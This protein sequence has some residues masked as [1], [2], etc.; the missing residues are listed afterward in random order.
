MWN[1]K[2]QALTFLFFITGV[3]SNLSGQYSNT[4]YFMPDIIQSRYLNPA[5][6]QQCKFTLGV[7]A[8]SSFYFNYANNAASYNDVLGRGVPHV[9]DPQETVN[10]LHKKNY[11]ETSIQPTLFS[12][13]YRHKD[14]T[15]SFDIIEKINLLVGIPKDLV[16]F[17]L[18]GNIKPG[19]LSGFL[20]SKNTYDFSGLGV[21][22]LHMREYAFG[23]AQDYNEY[24]SRGLRLKL[25]FGKMNVNTQKVKSSIYTN[26]EG[27]HDITMQT[28]NVINASL[29]LDYVINNNRI[30]GATYNDAG[31]SDI[32]LNRKNYGIAFDLGGIYSFYEPFVFHASLLDAGVIRWQTN[33]INVEQDGEFI[34]EG[35]DDLQD[36]DVTSYGREILDTLA[37]E[38]LY[39]SGNDGYYTLSP[40]KIYLGATYQMMENLKIGI[41]S[42]NELK[43]RRLFPSV[44]LSANYKPLKH[45]LATLSYT[46][47]NRSLNNIGFG[48]GVGTEVFQFYVIN[49]NVL[50]TIYP[51]TIQNMG[52]RFGMSMLFGCRERQ[53]ATGAG[54]FW[55]KDRLGTLK[56]PCK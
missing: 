39:S 51:Q 36:S 41:L 5:I 56:C 16:A 49:D 37:E 7:P 20:D 26:P 24:F 33:P 53:K 4:M 55:I 15:F 13:G 22:F 2:L 29:P 38:F 23:I 11:I 8:L 18:Y 17:P 34:Y 52:I 40:A 3:L 30:S 46:V 6:G 54:C 31:I 9:L 32:L 1:F 19:E 43:E 25:L 12:L 35:I 27:I 14:F 21:D 28:D 10:L 48:L 45:V 42:R 47:A 50:G 44:T